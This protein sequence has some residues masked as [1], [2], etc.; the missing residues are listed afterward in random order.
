MNHRD[1]P[2]NKRHVKRSSQKVGGRW[3]LSG[4]VSLC[5]FHPDSGFVQRFPRETQAVCRVNPMN[6]SQAVLLHDFALKLLTLPALF[7]LL[8]LVIL[9]AIL[10]PEP[11]EGSAISRWE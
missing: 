3:Y 5:Q 6:P 9:S 4:K 11:E 2:R 1:R 8:F 10:W 7:V